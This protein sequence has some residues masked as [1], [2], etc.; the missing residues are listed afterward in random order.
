MKKPESVTEVRLFLGLCSYY[1]KFIKDFSKI[2]KPLF[3]LVE[4][5]N[6]FK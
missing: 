1:R 2:A 3:Y 4:K 5:K 6:E